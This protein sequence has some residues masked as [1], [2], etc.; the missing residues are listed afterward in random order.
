MLTTNGLRDPDIGSD[1]AE[2][3]VASS[4]AMRAFRFF[5]PS[6]IESS[7]A[8]TRTEKSVKPVMNENV[9]AT[10]DAP[11]GLDLD[12]AHLLAVDDRIGVQRVVGGG[13]ELQDGEKRNQRRNARQQKDPFS[14]HH[15]IQEHAGHNQRRHPPEPVGAQTQESQ[16]Q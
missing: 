3:S 13:A 15:R 8:G 4:A 1:A 11:R 7:S 9:D 2:N 6:P 16:Q 10:R 12:R 14:P 5:S